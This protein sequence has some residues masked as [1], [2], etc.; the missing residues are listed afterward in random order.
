MPSRYSRSEKNCLLKVAFLE[1][2]QE[3]IK[4]VEDRM[5]SQSEGAHD[6]LALA[7]NHL[8]TSGGKRI[9]VGLTLLTGEML[10]GN[11]ET[12]VTLAASLELLHTATLVH[13]DLI[14]GSLIRR[15]I[16]TI[17]AQLSTPATVLTG[18]YIFARAAKLAA[19]V[20]LVP[21]MQ[22]FAQTLAT[23]VNGELTQLFSRRGI[24][25]REEYERRIYAKTASLFETASTSAGIVSGSSPDEVQR[26][27]Q[28]GYEIGMAFQIMDD[29]LDFTGEQATVGKPVANDLRQGIVTLPTLYFIESNPNDPVMEAVIQGDS[30]PEIDVDRLV[31]SIRTS[32]AVDRSIDEA[33]SH[34][35]RGLSMLSQFPDSTPRR[36]LE[37]LARFVVQR[38]N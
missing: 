7:L 26:V 18:D 32:G 21:V 1:P 19:D 12:L 28:F 36:G 15:G 11:R 4:Q 30:V 13:D 16:P 31:K 2:V 14:D 3:L 24:T 17:N 20:N 33:Q 5:L 25:G 6:Q 22:L 23:I 38:N 29:I 9:R 35:E 37:E 10:G 34:I 8:L 27:K